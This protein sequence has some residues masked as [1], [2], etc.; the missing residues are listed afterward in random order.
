M[1]SREILWIFDIIFFTEHLRWL[2]LE[3]FC[4]GTSLV[5]ILEFYH[6]N[7]FVI[8]RRFSRKIPIK[9]NNE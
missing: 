9:E 8:N 6:F 1:F 2:L 5:K 7:I 4:E 3:G